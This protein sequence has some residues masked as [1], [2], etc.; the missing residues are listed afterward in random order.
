MREYRIVRDGYAGYEVQ[1][2][3][4]DGVWMQPE[5]NTRFSKLEA[6]I[7]IWRHRRGETK[8]QRSGEVVWSS[9]S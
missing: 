9:D 3:T 7:F 1:W 5:I 8:K 2:K 6:K 4:D